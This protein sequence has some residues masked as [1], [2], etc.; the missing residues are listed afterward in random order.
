MA[1]RRGFFLAGAAAALAVASLS[2]CG[3]EP[4]MSQ[5]SHP[6]VQKEMQSIRVST[7]PDRSGQILRNYLL[8]ALAPKGR[9]GPELYTLTVR[10]YEPL[11]E[12]AIRRDDT[13]SR[14]S[15]TATVSF[16]LTDPL[17][18]PVFS[19]TSLVETTYEVTNSEFATL[20]N[21]A[22]AR[23]RALQDVSNDVRQQI[24][25]FLAGKTSAGSRR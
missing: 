1:S 4:L 24:A 14:L 6:R 19:G 8:D 25:T 15:Y 23:D 12:V 17:S 3:F 20:A 11:Q 2:G 13:A 22:S 7:I 5:T 18:T 16:Q 21:Q 10:L 9:Q